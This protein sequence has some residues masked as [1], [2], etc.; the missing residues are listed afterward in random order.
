MFI[1]ISD[2]QDSN[3]IVQKQTQNGS[4]SSTHQTLHIN[5]ELQQ[6]C[7]QKVPLIFPINLIVTDKASFYYDLISPT[8]SLPPHSIYLM[9]HSTKRTDR[10]P[11]AAPR[12]SVPKIQSKTSKLNKVKNRLKTGRSWRASAHVYTATMIFLS[13]EA[14]VSSSGLSGVSSG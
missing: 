7:N 4:G 2:I 10:F 6:G 11:S 13:I 3:S 14:T 5:R 12:A 8:L 1:C 9:F